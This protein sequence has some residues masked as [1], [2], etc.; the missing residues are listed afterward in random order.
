MGTI[1]ATQPD[2]SEHG[3]NS[4]SQAQS[5]RKISATEYIDSLI[6][7]D[8]NSMA[9]VSKFVMTTQPIGDIPDPEPVPLGTLGGLRSRRY[10]LQSQ[11]CSLNLTDNVPRGSPEGKNKHP[12]ILALVPKDTVAKVTG[13]SS[14]PFGLYLGS[15]QYQDSDKQPVDTGFCVFLNVA[16]KSIWIVFDR[17][18]RDDMGDRQSVKPSVH[19]LGDIP[20]PASLRGQPVDLVKLYD[21]NYLH[22]GFSN[23]LFG[24]SMLKSGCNVQVTFKVP[25]DGAKSPIP[26]I[27]ATGGQLV[28]RSSA[29]AGGQRLIE[30]ASEDHSQSKKLGNAAGPPPR[31][32]TH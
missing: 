23:I 26:R 31:V 29:T 6:Q 22:Q 11:L 25:E 12:Y 14:I 28:S 18:P 10:F 16:D 19:S 7:L 21:L 15:L 9:S 20:W 17:E 1:S 3:T 32:P 2:N 8:L 24:E 4:S 5:A 27:R 13:I 30:K